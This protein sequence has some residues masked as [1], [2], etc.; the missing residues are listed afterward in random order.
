[1]YKEDLKK[2]ITEEITTC[3]ESI[4]DFAQVACPETQYKQL[5]SKILRLCNDLMR[6]LIVYVEEK[7]L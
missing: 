3:M 1:M 7:D 2:K 5:R 6:S 4:L